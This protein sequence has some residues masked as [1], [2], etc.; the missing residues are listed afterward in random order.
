MD[1]SG[2]DRARFVHAR[3]KRPELACEARELDE[4]RLGNESR[5]PGFGPPVEIREVYAGRAF[6]MGIPCG[7]SKEQQTRSGYDEPRCALH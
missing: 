7:K 2:R 5:W 1:A 6:E 4:P 3:G